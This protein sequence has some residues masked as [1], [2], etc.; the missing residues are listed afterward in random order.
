MHKS[1]RDLVVKTIL[2]I[3]HLYDVHVMSIRTTACRSDHIPVRHLSTLE[4]KRTVEPVARTSGKLC[5]S[6]PEA[7]STTVGQQKKLNSDP[8]YLQNFSA[9]ELAPP[10][11]P[12]RRQD[13][14]NH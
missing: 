9:C 12:G 11:W 2:G 14:S 6:R 4:A 3:A 8:H 7:K 1:D 13:R 5:T 10:S